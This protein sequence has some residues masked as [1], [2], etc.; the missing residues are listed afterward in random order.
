MH[1]DKTRVKPAGWPIEFIEAF[2][3]TSRKHKILAAIHKIPQ[4]YLTM[5]TTVKNEEHN[6]T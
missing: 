6:N 5:A 2:H 3:Q 4:L 1:S